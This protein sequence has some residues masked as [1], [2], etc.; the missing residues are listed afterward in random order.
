[1]TFSPRPLSK[2]AQLASR[3]RSRL[4]FWGWSRAGAR[5][6]TSAA[7]AISTRHDAGTTTTGTSSTI[8]G[9]AVE[10][11][12]PHLPP[13]G[14]CRRRPTT[15]PLCTAGC[16]SDDDCS[17]G[18]T[19]SDQTSRQCKNGFACTIATT[20]GTFCCESMC[21][22]KDFIDTTQRLH[23]ASDRLHARPVDLQERALKRER[24]F[25][26]FAPLALALTE[27]LRYGPS[28]GR[29]ARGSRRCRRRRRRGTCG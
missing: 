26:G 18:E 21:V 29:R 17:D 8:Q 19:T 4:L 12:T 24:G 5:T 16:C 27:S 20:V 23:K 7:S 11:P 15:G 6:S 2:L 22:C 10:C 3:S 9:Q 1:M 25:A 14:R 28:R 13:A